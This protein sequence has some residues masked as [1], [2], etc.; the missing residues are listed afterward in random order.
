ML[1]FLNDGC[2]AH[3]FCQLIQ[4]SAAAEI[5]EMGYNYFLTNFLIRLQ[6]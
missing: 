5:F 2:F 1:I 4:R 3:E 6:F